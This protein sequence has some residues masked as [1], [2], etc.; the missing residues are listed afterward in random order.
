M[1]LN[2]DTYTIETT[3]EGEFEEIVARTT[4]ALSEQGFGVLCDIDLQNKFRNELDEEFS[5]YRILGACNPPLAYEALT[6][7][8]ELGALLPCNVIVYELDDGSVKVRAVDPQELLSVTANSEL[9]PIADE[10][11]QRLD[12]VVD[13]VSGF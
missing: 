7:E 6:E 10:V 3:V 5:R 2:D 4:E 12:T 11:R 9:H 13:E 8:I 1:G